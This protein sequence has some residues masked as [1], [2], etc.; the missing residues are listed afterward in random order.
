MTNGTVNGGDRGNVED[1]RR[2][3]EWLVKTYRA[4]VDVAYIG[5]PSE[6]GPALVEV[7][8]G[9]GIPACRCYRCGALLT[10][11][12]VSPDR[13]VPGCV[14]TAEY[15]NGG[16]YARKNLRPA[17]LR[18]QCITGNHIKASLAGKRRR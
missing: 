2:R 8:F 9:T 11:D 5:W 13:I 14:K 16:T 18:C 17:C 10:A 1:R 3:K 15:P 4:D 6:L 12:R 7:P